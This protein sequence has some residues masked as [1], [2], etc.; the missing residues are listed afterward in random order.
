[1]M[2]RNLNLLFQYKYACIYTYKWAKS[3][4]INLICIHIR[5]TSP[6]NIADRR[7]EKNGSVALIV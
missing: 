7:T 6:R 2:Q 1:M 5:H 4:L 3:L